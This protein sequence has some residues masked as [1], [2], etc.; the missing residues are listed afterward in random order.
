M[1][2]QKKFR[3]NAIEKLGHYVYALIDPSNNNIFYVGKASSNNRAF[4]HLKP[5]GDEIPPIPTI[6]CGELI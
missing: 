2:K 5:T 6:I 4:D 3:Q 1:V